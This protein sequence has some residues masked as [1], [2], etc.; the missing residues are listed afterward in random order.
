MKVIYASLLILLSA[1]VYAQQTPYEISN[2]QE[3]A[4]YE[5]VI[6]YYKTLDKQYEQ[7][8]LLTYGPTDFGAPLHLFVLSKDQDFDPVSIRNKDKRILL[9]NN[10]IHPGEPEG[11]DA[12]MMLSRD[13]LSKDALPDNIVIC[14][15][16]LYNI[17]GSF[18]RS[19]TSRA[20]QNG[21]KAYGFRGNSKNY[22][23]NRDFIKTDSKNAQSFQEIFMHWNPE[24]FV[25]N[26]T[27]NGSDYQ[28]V[29]TLIPTQ[30]DKLNPII[31]EYLSQKMVPGIYEKMADQGYD[32]V[33]YVQFIGETPE[34]GIQQ[35]FESPRYST[36]YASLHNS[37]GFMPETHMLKDYK[38]R[39]DAT[40]ALMQC[41]IEIVHDDAQILAKNKKLADQAV[42]TQTSFPLQWTLDTT[43]VDSLLFKGYKGKHKPS[44]V[45]GLPRLYYDRQDPYEKVIPVLNTFKP[46]LS[47]EKPKA[48]IIPQAWSRVTDLL[49]L[50]GVK[51]DTLRQDTMVQVESYYLSDYKT[52]SKPYEGHYMHSE[53]QVN[54]VLQSIQ[55]YAGDII[56]HTNQSK[57]LYIINTL[58]PQGMDSF[59]AWNF[60]DSI[61]DQKEHFS[62]YIFEDTAVEILQQN[63]ELKKA[64]DAKKASDSA[65]AS[66]AY[67]QLEFIYKHSDY[68]EPS[69]NRYPIGRIL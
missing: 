45:S 50:N 20:N 34:E 37:I 40:Y 7:A 25:D 9:F 69:H 68:Y 61:L 52:M 8:K 13:L 67:A 32:L 29:M 26:H 27:S 18:N 64:L 62:S 3:T 42:Q 66:N 12:S 54:P 43:K 35:Y 51:L 65:F 17:G 11:I 15:I 4:E 30:K 39:V 1:F 58:E 53:V 44:Q 47:I 22:N 23:L 49:H 59:F 55:Y 60:F 31:S 63:P 28:H 21:P 19:S 48:Y 57:N 6:E 16:P 14:I 2:F 5:Q 41:F 33:P 56:V 24:V 10:G 36:G 46:T 38:S